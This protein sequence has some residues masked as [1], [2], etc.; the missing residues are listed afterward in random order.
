MKDPELNKARRLP[1]LRHVRV[2]HGPR[3]RTALQTAKLV[4]LQT[5]VFISTDRAL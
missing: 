5:R 1:V 2:F 3:D 4:R